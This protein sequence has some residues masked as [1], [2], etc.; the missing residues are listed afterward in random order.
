MQ[1]LVEWQELEER[2]RKEDERRLVEEKTQREKHLASMQKEKDLRKC[3]YEA[4]ETELRRIE[5]SSPV[6]ISVYYNI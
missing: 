4:F 1:L 6:T 2:L 5:L 3:R